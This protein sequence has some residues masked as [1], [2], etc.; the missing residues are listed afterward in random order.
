MNSD[1]FSGPEVQYMH[2]ERYKATI[3]RFNA[4]FE[5]NLVTKTQVKKDGYCL[6]KTHSIWEYHFGSSTSS[7]VD[8]FLN[9]SIIESRTL[10]LLRCGPLSSTGIS[11]ILFSEGL[12]AGVQFEKSPERKQRLRML[13]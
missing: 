12:P 6:V 13:P 2:I 5:F 8:F 10:L 4:I 1:L 9:I 7:T 3:L 11:T